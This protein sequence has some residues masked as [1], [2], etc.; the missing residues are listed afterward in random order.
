MKFV[1]GGRLAIPNSR[2]A[3][4]TGPFGTLEQAE[5]YIENPPPELGD[6]GTITLERGPHGWVV[7]TREGDLREPAAVAA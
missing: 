2:W 5:A 7:W 6:P 4:L 1:M 3:E